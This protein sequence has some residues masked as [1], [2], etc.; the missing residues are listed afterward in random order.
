MRITRIFKTLFKNTIHIAAL[1]KKSGVNLI[2]YINKL[3]K[4]GF[5]LENTA[6]FNVR[7]KTYFI[8]TYIIDS[9][10][11]YHSTTLYKDS[12]IFLLTSLPKISSLIIPQTITK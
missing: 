12:T 10:N 1:M 3:R 8:N 5:F 6:L 7:N 2:Y 11:K 4:T 9:I